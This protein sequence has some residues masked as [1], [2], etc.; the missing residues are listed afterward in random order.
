MA[1]PACL[2]EAIGLVDLHPAFHSQPM[3]VSVDEM[4]LRER[5]IET[6]LLCMKMI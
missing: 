3:L 4:G 6:L 5:N 2:Q 1:I